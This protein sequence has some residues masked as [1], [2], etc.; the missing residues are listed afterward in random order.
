MIYFVKL[1]LTK[2]LRVVEKENCN[3][4]LYVRKAKHIHK[5]QTHFSSERMLHKEYYNNNSVEKR[6]SGRESQEAWRQD[7]LIGGKAPVIK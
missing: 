1:V 2:D 6:I 5:R 3:K 4:M 7:N